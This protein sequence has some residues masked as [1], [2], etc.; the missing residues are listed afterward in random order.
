MTRD[1]P[2]HRIPDDPEPP[3]PPDLPEPPD[4]ARVRELRARLD[5]DRGPRRP[6]PR[7]GRQARDIGAYTLIPMMMLAGPALGYGLGLLVER[8]LGGEPWVSV[9]GILF[10][11]AAAFRQIFLLLARRR[12]PED[13]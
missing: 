2:E 13:R 1:D 4:P 10:G 5:H 6:A 12:A 11:L 7:G 8:K 3:L 9:G